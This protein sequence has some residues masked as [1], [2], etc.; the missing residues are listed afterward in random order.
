RACASCQQV[1]KQQD[2]NNPA[3]FEIHLFY[4][5]PIIKQLLRSLYKFRCPIDLAINLGMGQYL[6]CPSL[7]LYSLITVL[8]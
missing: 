2:E 5:L 6:S 4:S 3:S 7:F 1:Y 8:Y